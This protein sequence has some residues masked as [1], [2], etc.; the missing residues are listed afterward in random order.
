MRRPIASE[1]N[2]ASRDA[3]PVGRHLIPDHV[4]GTTHMQTQTSLF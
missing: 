4:T 3:T 2:V 1:Y